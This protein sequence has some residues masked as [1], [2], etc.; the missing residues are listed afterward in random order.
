MMIQMS[1]FAISCRCCQ[2]RSCV[3]I[4]LDVQLA[5]QKSGRSHLFIVSAGTMDFHRLS[6]HALSQRSE[7]K[8]GP[9]MPFKIFY[10]EVFKDKYFKL[11]AKVTRNN[12]MAGVEKRMSKW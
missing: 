10:T 9:Q 5:K 1:T 8:A 11:V 6:G 7:Q 12:K 3:V 4:S 2:I